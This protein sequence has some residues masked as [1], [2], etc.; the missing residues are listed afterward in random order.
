MGERGLPSMSTSSPA[1]VY[2]SCPQPTA[3]KGHTDSVT[4]MPAILAS[5]RRV[6]SDAALGPMPQ[7]ITRPMTGT[8]R[9]DSNERGR[10]PDGAIP[11][12]PDRAN[13]HRGQ[14]EAAHLEGY[15]GNVLRAALTSRI[16]G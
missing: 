10:D 6:R 1:R 7:S 4:F 9:S 3:Q 14:L 16:A 15:I 13:R 12:C 5:A 11:L 2:T 8:R